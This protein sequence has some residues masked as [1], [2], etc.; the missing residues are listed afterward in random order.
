MGLGVIVSIAYTPIMLRLLGQSEYGLYTLSSSIVSYLSILSL[1]FGS[2]YVRFYSRYKVKNEEDNIAKLNGM[3]MTVY[4]IIG[5]VA[6]IAGGILT[7]YTDVIFRAKLSVQEIGTTKVL[8]SLLVINIAVS[9]PF[10][11]FTSYITAN[12]QYIF[13]RVLSLIKVL[14]NPLIVL[15]IL[16]MGY[17]SIGLVISTVLLN[18][19][20]EIIYMVFCLKKLQM[21]FDFRA[22]D[23]NLLKEI[24]IFSSFILMN[25]I[26]DQIN[27]NVDKFL[28]G[29]YWGSLSV[30][31]YGLASQ[32]NGYYMQFAS[33]ISTVFIPRVHRIVSTGNDKSELTDIFTKVGRIQ[34]IILSLISTGL[35]F[36]GKPF[37]LKWGG[38]DYGDAYGIV[39]SLTLPA[40]IPLIQNL[41]IEIQRAQNLHKFR[42]LL[43]LFIAI[44]NIFL[45]IPLCKKYGGLGAA[46]GTAIAIVLGNGIIMNIY[47]HKKC[48]LNIKMF[49]NNILKLLP[50]LLLPILSGCFINKFIDLNNTVMLIIFILIY[51]LIY[52]ISMWMFGLNRYEKNLIIKPIKRLIKHGGSNG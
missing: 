43:Y 29:L 15:P 32:L 41:G 10:S 17:K 35:I 46:I 48:N 28:L 44:L 23:I 19:I 36:F 37:I 40:T 1:G 31:I 7:S 2:A 8:M 9:F 49:W 33:T 34:F 14:A 25:I 39:L 26:V 11:V 30:A 22:F 42:S 47:Y 16:F 20:I 45:S 12:E 5:I 4:I 3:Y 6:L 18:I 21:R 38:S 52:S 27:W 50:A 51:T 24:A 13:Q